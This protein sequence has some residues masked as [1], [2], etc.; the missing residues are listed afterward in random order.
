MAKSGQLDFKWRLKGAY[1]CYCQQQTSQS[2]EQS[3]TFSKPLFSKH[4][5]EAANERWKSA[6]KTNES[7]AGELSHIPRNGASSFR[8]VEEKWVTLSATPPRS[9]RKWIS[10]SEAG[11]V[12]LCVPV[13][14][15]E[16]LFWMSIRSETLRSVLDVWK[17]T[18]WSSPEHQKK[19]TWTSSRL[20]LLAMILKKYIF[21][22]VFSIQGDA[23]S[24]G[25][26][27]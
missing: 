10:Q 26:L 2:T 27:D 5:T 3:H 24:I 7:P 12:R 8:F 4:P 18:C 25:I 6:T 21:F 1:L 19:K 15:A 20:A 14:G 16:R 13:Q 9:S 11:E 17:T 23:K 22:N